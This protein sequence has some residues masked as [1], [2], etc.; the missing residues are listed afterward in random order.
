MFHRHVFHASLVGLGI[1]PRVDLFDELAAAYGE[2]SR[3][4]HTQQ[5]IAECLSQFQRFHSLAQRPYEVEVALWFHDAVYDTHRSD[6]EE[7]SAQWAEQYLAAEDANAAVINRIVDMIIATKSHS[8]QE[9]DAAIVIDIDLGILGASPKAFEVYDQAIRREYDW[10]SEA[11]YRPTRRQILKIF[12]DQDVIYQTEAVR[13][14]YETQ[15]RN[16]LSRKIKE[17]TTS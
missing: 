3:H 6:N 4:Y 9:G 2:R 14:C 13:E 10:V 8:R 11:Q 5:H 12:L 7:R 15:A 16:N 17:L 1:E